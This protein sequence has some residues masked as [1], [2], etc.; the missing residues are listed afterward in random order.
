MKWLKGKGTRQGR[1]RPSSPPAVML[2]SAAAPGAGLVSLIP[3]NPSNNNCQECQ[4]MMPI[5]CLV[6][7]VKLSDTCS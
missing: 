3:Y 4:V 7:H 2:S 6:T 5:T 1:V